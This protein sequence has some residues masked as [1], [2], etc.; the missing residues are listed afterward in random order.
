MGMPKANPADLQ[1]WWKL[2]LLAPRR[3]FADRRSGGEAVA[4]LKA[5]DARA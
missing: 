3:A 2:R 5:E 4:L 1:R